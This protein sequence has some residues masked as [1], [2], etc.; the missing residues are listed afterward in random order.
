MCM[1]YNCH[2]LIIQIIHIPKTQF[3]IIMLILNIYQIHKI[4]VIL[5]LKIDFLVFF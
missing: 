3:Y 2:V 5:Y 1:M 4:S